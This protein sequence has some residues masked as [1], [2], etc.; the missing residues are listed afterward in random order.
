[1]NLDKGPRIQGM[2]YV[3]TNGAMENEIAAF[4]RME[5]GTLE[6]AGFFPTGG[7]GTGNSSVDPLSSQG[8]LRL[9]HFGCFLFAV[10][11]GSNTVSSFRV[12][13]N[14][15]LS[16]ASV[17]DSGGVKPNSLDESCGFLYV[18]N[19][20][21]SENDIASNITGFSVDRCGILRMVPCPTVSLSTFNAQP[22]S[23]LFR[24]CGKQLVV[25]EQN[26]NRISV[27]LIGEEGTAR[28]QAVND[29]NGAGPF[30]SA[31][32]RDS[33]LL[34]V[35]AG[36]NALSSYDL[37]PNGRLKVIS[38]SVPTNQKAS[39]WVSVSPCGHHAYVSST[40]SGAITLF[41]VREDGSL[42]FVESVFSTP[43]GAGMPIDNGVSPCGCN[44]YALNGNQG[45]IS[46]F[47][48]RDDGRLDRI[49]VTA[50]GLLPELGTQGLAV[51]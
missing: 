1:M 39:C 16:L 24:P 36:A 21:S 11:A 8:S 48:I 51:L 23:V 29:S 41:D 31:F 42:S 17:V 6:L 38:G 4:K 2:V 26:T 40:G 22:S 3:M 7:R 44:F 37:G 19:V 20:G 32:P 50:G 33:V 49:Q 30:G 35:E 5:D 10:N 12:K 14:G 46:V 18:S 28:L 13:E 27:Y 45:T 47:A 9:S 34:V 43:N 15:S 25:S